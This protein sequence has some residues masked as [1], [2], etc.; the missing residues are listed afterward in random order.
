MTL[1]A[2]ALVNLLMMIFGFKFIMIGNLDFMVGLFAIVL[3]A[4]FVLKDGHLFT[5][6]RLLF[7]FAD[8]QR[9]SKPSDDPKKVGSIKN[10]PIKVNSLAMYFLV[11]GAVLIIAG[12]IFSV[13]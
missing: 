7:H 10:Q 9:D 5:G 1:I 3:T 12:V 6:W 2:A 11:I 4:F 8:S 13:I